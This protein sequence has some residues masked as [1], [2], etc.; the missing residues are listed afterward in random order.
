MKNEQI[1][2]ILAKE[3]LT[4]SAF[5]EKTGIQRSAV[6]HLLSKRNKVSLDVVMRIHAAF[7]HINSIWLLDGTG[8]YYADANARPSVPQEP[9]ASPAESDLFEGRESV[10]PSGQ[11]PM[12]KEDVTLP[13]DE[14]K[15][16]FQEAPIG[17]S[18][19]TVPSRGKNVPS[20]EKNHP[21]SKKIIPSSEAG[22]PSMALRQ[23]SEENTQRKILNITVF[24]NDGTYETFQPTRHES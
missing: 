17:S 7:P 11:P 13:P 8:E 6:S 3:N 21:S 15:L 19:D 16:I 9:H 12:K 23:V 10:S 18:T 1:N 5:A 2:E 14:P 4:A 24:Y 22:H 20:S